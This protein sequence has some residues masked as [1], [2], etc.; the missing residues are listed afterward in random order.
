MQYRENIRKEVTPARLRALLKLVSRAYY[1]R[2][3]LEGLLQPSSLNKGDSPEFRMVYKFA[4]GTGLIAEEENKYIKLNIDKDIVFNDYK[5]KKKMI[6][7]LLGNQEGL[8]YKM[9]SWALEQNEEI[10][11]FSKAGDLVKSMREKNINVKDEDVLAWRIWFKYLGY[12]HN[13][14]G[15]YIIPNP[16]KRIEDLVENELEF[17]NKD[18]IAIRE[19]TGELVSKAPEFNT[20]I[21]RNNLSYPLSVSLRILNEQKKIKL[22]YKN[23]T[24][25][26]WHLY[27]MESE[28]LNDISH[29]RIGGE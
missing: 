14:H 4:M 5:Y 18:R 3:E 6:E 22:S 27:Y 20:S 29:I 26:I 1:T 2:D 25:D 11:K 19:F 17:T 16:F 28:K 12:G 21:D 9:T 15:E 7:I 10:V 13:L 24:K 23:D 8:F